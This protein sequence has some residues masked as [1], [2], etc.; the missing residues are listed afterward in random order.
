MRKKWSCYFKHQL[1]ANFQSRDDSIALNRVAET[2]RE[3]VPKNGA[4]QRSWGDRDVKKI[5]NGENKGEKKG[6]K[7]QE[8]QEEEQEQQEQGHVQ[9][10]EP[11]QPKQRCGNTPPEVEQRRDRSQRLSRIVKRMEKEAKKFI[12]RIREGEKR[13]RELEGIIQMLRIRKGNINS[14]YIQ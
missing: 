5:A 11:Q 1:S 4:L 9:N 8:E 3:K 13:E 12:R 6:A 14:L 10:S 7:E 2:L